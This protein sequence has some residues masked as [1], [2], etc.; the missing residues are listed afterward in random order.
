M[1]G[2]TGTGKC[3][4]VGF[5]FQLTHPM[6]GATLRFTFVV[7]SL[8]FQLTHPMWDATICSCVMS[9][10]SLISTH[11]PHVGC[12]YVSDC[13]NTSNAYF[14]SHTPCG[15]RLNGNICF[16]IVIKFQ[17]THPM[18]GATKSC[19]NPTSLALISTHTP[20]VGCDKSQ[21]DFIP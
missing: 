18:W 6:R 17:L 15:V 16:I 21:C 5:K 1:W 13:K 2:A 11:T 14:N 20:H 9:L 8:A 10:S 3:L 4:G 12:D 7:L 19:R